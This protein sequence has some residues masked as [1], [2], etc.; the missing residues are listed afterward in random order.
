MAKRRAFQG[1]G[2]NLFWGRDG[3]EHGFHDQPL[4]RPTA[5]FAATTPTPRRRGQPPSRPRRHR[6]SQ[7]C[8]EA[9]KDV[10][11]VLGG[12]EGSLRRIAHYD[13]WSD[14][15]RRSIVVD[16]MRPAALRQRR[17][18]VGRGGAP[19]TR[20]NPWLTSPTCAAPPSGAA[21]HPEGWF[22][23][24][25]AKWTSRAAWK[26]TSTPE[27]DHQRAGGPAGRHLQLQDTTISIADSAQQISAE[28]KT[29]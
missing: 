26:T 1:A 8:R 21:H 9:Y 7:R 19:P 10:P 20:A 11:I 2:P 4:A 5:K 13:Y 29:T 16:A 3:G 24:D 22:E 23:I 15:V 25:S 27:P 17:A 14:K 18:C 6:V 12:I 28:A